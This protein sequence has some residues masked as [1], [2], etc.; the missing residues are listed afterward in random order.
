MKLNKLFVI[1]V[2]AG[3]LGLIGCGDDAAPQNGTGGTNGGGGPNCTQELCMNNETL[4][5]NC[6]REYDSCITTGTLSQ[7]E[8]IAFAEETCTI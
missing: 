2:L 8:C 3:T 4:S 7:Q 1:G 6:Q 5:A